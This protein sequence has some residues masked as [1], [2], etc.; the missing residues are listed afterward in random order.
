MIGREGMAV[1]LAFDIGLHVNST[2][3][4]FSETERQVRRQVM[5]ACV[6]FDRYWSL[7]LGRPTSIKHGDIAIE[8]GSKGQTDL[9]GSPVL[10]F[11][12]IN[13]LSSQDATQQLSP[14]PDV[15]VDIHQQLVTLMD[16]A[17]QIADA[18]NA[19]YKSAVAAPS[20][21]VEAQYLHTID[22]DRQ[23]QDWYLSLPDHLAWK[24]DN[25]KSAPL[26]FFLLHQQYHVC[27]I[28]LH[29]PWANYG[30]TALDA[31]DGGC[32][33]SPV[34]SHQQDDSASQF[35]MPPSGSVGHDASGRR[36]SD[37]RSRVFLSRKI[38]T[39]HAV[40]TA[41]IFWQ[42][43][44]RFNGRKLPFVAIQHAGTSAIA[45]LAAL[46][47]RTR[48][49][50]Q[51]SN[52]RYLQVLSAAIY[53]MSHIYQPA[54]KMYHLLKAMLVEI[55]N[56]L[57]KQST[58]DTVMMSSQ[59]QQ[60][61]APIS[62][63]NQETAHNNLQ[64]DTYNNGSIIFGTDRR[65]STGGETAHPFIPVQMNTYDSEHNDVQP[66]KKRR[67]VGSRSASELVHP[68]FSLFTVSQSACPTPPKSS[69]SQRAFGGNNDH[70][71]GRHH[72]PAITESSEP[73][74]HP[75]SFELEFLDVMAVDMDHK[76][77]SPSAEDDGSS[78][79]S[80]SASGGAPESNITT[81]PSCSDDSA[82]P[83]TPNH[84]VIPSAPDMMC[85]DAKL[86]P[87]TNNDKDSI[88]VVEPEVTIQ[89]WLDEPSCVKSHDDNMMMGQEPAG[90]AEANNSKTD[91]E[92]E[93]SGASDDMVHHYGE[94]TNNNNTNTH[95]T[96]TSE[97]N[98]L[99]WFA[100][101]LDT[102]LEDLV[103]SIEDN[104][105]KSKAAANGAGTSDPPRNHALDFLTL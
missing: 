79:S 4:E 42:H 64:G 65:W 28:L 55:R 19:L 17:G 67:C 99:E 76:E 43:R 78:A 68:M 53:D 37:T 32:Y 24:A 82:G 80:S 92:H 12:M 31:S 59:T 75:T 23:L 96:S 58:F 41:R 97:D 98:T 54:A 15:N 47:H 60:H 44:Q 35:H 38:C 74:P 90:P 61:Q 39:L 1:R 2:G 48:D 27:M 63:M 81:P 6:L 84:L 100:D 87:L 16:L 89:E 88:T 52:L 30:P 5:T 21:V 49:V 71:D 45:L 3:A 34:S 77:T 57:V 102:R 56:E 25:T 46:A 20:E 69:G 73:S 72:S 51:P 66:F 40:R 70:D 62:H 26:G 95:E 94:V 91:A 18:Q 14:S 22:L 36:I 13:H 11:G 8:L 10:P 85:V 103:R 7:L 105:D 50:D 29:R 101:A 9:S 83:M 104:R 93:Y 33:P 86:E